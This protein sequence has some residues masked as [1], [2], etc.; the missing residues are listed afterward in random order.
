MNVENKFENSA[1]DEGDMWKTVINL[2]FSTKVLTLSSICQTKVTRPEEATE[3][4]QD[5]GDQV[6]QDLK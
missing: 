2:L 5:Y 6:S 4:Y 3:D 1:D